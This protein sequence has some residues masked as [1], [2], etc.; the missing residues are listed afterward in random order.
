MLG[1]PG[2]NSYYAHSIKRVK[3]AG[4]EVFAE[5]LG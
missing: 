1:I 5:R 2:Y 4:L 3:K